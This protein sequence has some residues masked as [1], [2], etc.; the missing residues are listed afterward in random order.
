MYSNLLEI[1]CRE[2]QVLELATK[3]S[4]I[5]SLR[6][7]ISNHESHLWRVP[8]LSDPPHSERGGRRSSSCSQ[9]ATSLLRRT[10]TKLKV[11]FS[12]VE[13]E[14][15]QTLPGRGASCCA[16]GTNWLL[17][18]FNSLDWVFLCLFCIFL[19]LPRRHEDGRVGYSKDKEGGH[20]S[21]VDAYPAMMLQVSEGNLS[22]E[23]L[24]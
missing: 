22:G 19:S 14:W 9:H 6:V 24:A 20:S 1:C 15:E 12:D 7:N 18:L 10:I 16:P 11:K 13:P 3:A 21:N 4:S 17:G 2:G 23:A 8:K 5:N